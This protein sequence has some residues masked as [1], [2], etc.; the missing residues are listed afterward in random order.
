[1]IKLALTFG[2]LYGRVARGQGRDL[3]N[4]AGRVAVEQA[5]TE[6]ITRRGDPSLTARMQPSAFAVYGMKRRTEGYMKD[7][8]RANGVAQP[9]ASPRRFNWARIAQIIAKGDKADP[10]QLLN[11]L[12]AIQRRNTTP[13]RQLVVRPGGYRVRITGGNKVRARITLPGARALNRGGSR[14]EAYRRE[15]LDFSKGAG[16]DSRWI[17][18]RVRDLMFANNLGGRGVAGART[19]LRALATGSA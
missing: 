8:I 17:W 1:M 12:A 3:A 7:Q 11:A 16:R 10:R 9:Y 6:W 5:T 15:L 18:R 2:G 4:R 13:M 19:P 14:N